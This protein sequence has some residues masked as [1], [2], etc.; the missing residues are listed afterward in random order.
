MFP[1]SIFYLTGILD[2]G[3]GKTCF[4]SIHFLLWFLWL[5][6]SLILSILYFIELY[7]ITYFTVWLS[8]VATL[9][10]SLVTYVTLW[11]KKSQILNLKKMVVNFHGTKF[12][13][14][15]L[16]KFIQIPNL[17]LFLVY[18]AIILYLQLKTGNISMNIRDILYIGAK[19]YAL[20]FYVITLPL[21]VTLLYAN[22]CYWCSSELYVIENRIKCISVISNENR[23]ISILNYYQSILNIATSV[24]NAFSTVTFFSMVSYL[25]IAFAC[26]GNLVK[27]IVSGNYYLIFIVSLN[28]VFAVFC[29]TILIVY[30]SETP[31]IIE[32]INGNLFVLEGKL[33]LTLNG[34]NS[35]FIKKFIKTFTKR[36]VFTFSACNMVHFKRSLIITSYGTLISYGLLLLQLQ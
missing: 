29:M 26:M 10:I 12:M 35:K 9:V 19:H 14:S 7:I 5:I 16:L 3:S 36:K 28:F 34:R 15:T 17:V 6:L 13:Q 2:Y 8:Y 18:P 21:S 4:S 30:A 22:F 33:S 24:E 11:L 23:I 27:R 25:F 31:L 20:N 1:S 32:R